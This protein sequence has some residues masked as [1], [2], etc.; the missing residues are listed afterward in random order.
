MRMLM[1]RGMRARLDP[2]IDHRSLFAGHD[3]APDLV[4]DLLLRHGRQLVKSRDDRHAFSSA[5]DIRHFR[6]DGPA[7]EAAG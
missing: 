5:Q 3:A 4:G 7:R 6:I 2:P 1:S